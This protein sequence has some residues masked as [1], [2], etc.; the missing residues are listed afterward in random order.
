MATC[1]GDFT[2]ATKVN[3]PTRD[4]VDE[5][6]EE[7]GINRSEVLR[8]LLDLYH[9]SEDGELECPSCMKTVR[10]WVNDVSLVADAYGETSTEQRTD[11]GA[12]LRAEHGSSIDR[13][14]TRDPAAT[15]DLQS[16]VMELESVIESQQQELEY[17]RNELAD[18]REAIDDHSVS[19]VSQEDLVRLEEQLEWTNDQVRQMIP[20]IEVLTAVSDLSSCG[21]CPDCGEDLVANQPI[22]D[23]GGSSAIECSGCAR[24]LG[25]RE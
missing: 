10:I 20:R 5:S 17:L 9:Q 3:E 8:R 6:A 16:R 24:I 25:H 19:R 21:I 7:I 15:Q 22:F 4:L 2:I 23:L 12:G 13:A 18:D 11:G 14:N 1:Q